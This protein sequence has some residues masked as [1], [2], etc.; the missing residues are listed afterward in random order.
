MEWTYTATK[1]PEVLEVA[2]TNETP[3]HSVWDENRLLKLAYSCSIYL[4]GGF[5][6]AEQT[7]YSMKLATPF[8]TTPLTTTQLFK[9]GNVAKYFI[10]LLGIGEGMECCTAPFNNRRTGL[11]PNNCL[12]FRYFNMDP[13]K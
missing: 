9:G 2:E 10:D 6:E 1:N 8:D 7:D 11:T 12:I 3:A 5:E 4:S 13:V